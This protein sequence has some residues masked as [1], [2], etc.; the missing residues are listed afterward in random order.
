M[1]GSLEDTRC[2]RAAPPPWISDKGRVIAV[3]R[4]LEFDLSLGFDV[5]QAANI[6]LRLTAGRGRSGG[7]PGR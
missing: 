1:G 2:S 7:P 3:K 5:V 6:G 4:A